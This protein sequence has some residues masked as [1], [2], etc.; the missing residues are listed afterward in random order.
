[1]VH[2]SHPYMTTGKTIGLTGKA[3]KEKSLLVTI[4]LLFL[5]LLG[6]PFAENAFCV[7]S[8]KR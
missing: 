3:G 4:I 7:G 5:L 1:M 2:L 8:E 6:E